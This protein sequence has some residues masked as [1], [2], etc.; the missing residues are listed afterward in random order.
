M[1]RIISF[2]LF[3]VLTISVNSMNLT[4]F[5]PDRV[6]RW[7]VS[8]PDSYYNNETLYNYIDGA[9][10]L[11]L[12]YGFDTV[13][14]RRYTCENEPDI[15]VEIFNMLQPRNAFGV[16]TNM[17]EKNQHQFGQGSQ[18][19]KG[20]LIFWKDHYF[21]SVSTERSTQASLDAINK[22]AF[23]IDKN[24]IGKGEL[25]EIMQFLPQNGL[26]EEGYCYFH[27]YIWLN[28]YYFIS[29]DNILNISEKTD[30]VLAKYGPADHRSYLLIVQYPSEEEALT[31]FR[32]FKRTYAPEL[33]KENLVQLED[34]TWHTAIL[35]KNLVAAVFNAK[36][37]D[38]A[39]QL[40]AQWK[41]LAIQ[42]NKIP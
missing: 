38:D 6:N 24:I 3:S 15:V 5:L 18:L 37:K 36:T 17:R 40:I 32:Q 28:A 30:C 11:Y 42:K 20:S 8:Q 13:V 2:V 19:I 23:E 16:F 10:E 9:T 22:L 35:D 26:V 29:N 14:S 33:N 4:K 25:P 41:T 31:A 34:K 21:V 27:H 7:A 1:Q 39:Q 12:S